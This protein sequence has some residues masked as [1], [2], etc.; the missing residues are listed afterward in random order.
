VRDAAQLLVE[1]DQ[2]HEGQEV[3]DVGARQ[4]RAQRRDEQDQ[5]VAVGRDEQ[6]AGRD[7]AADPAA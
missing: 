1:D 4:A 7:H 3:A 5:E 6:A 2:G